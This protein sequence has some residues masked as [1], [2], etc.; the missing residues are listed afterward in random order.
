METTTEYEL[1]TSDWQDASRERPVSQPPVLSLIR[2]GFSTFGPLAP[3]LAARLAYL[4]FTTPRI[5]ARH[6]TSDEW[7][8]KAR[9]FEITYKSFRLKAYEWG[10][11]E[12]VILLVHGW[13]SR[14]TALRSFVPALLERG[15][16][17]VAFDG[18]AHGDSGGKRTNIRHFA[19]A[20]RSIMLELGGVY[21]II[22]HSFGG[23]STIYALGLLNSGLRMAKAVFI[24]TPASVIPIYE[25]IVRTLNL[26][27][28]VAMHFKNLME[29]IAGRPLVDLDAT[30]GLA[31]RHIGKILLIHDRKDSVVP[32]EGSFAMAAA[33]ENAHLLLTDG[34]GH[35]RLMKNPD[36]VN[37]VGEF[38]GEE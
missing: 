36:L 28:S 11:G 27:P 13:E 12:R 21:G 38:F 22:G 30:R 29:R 7:L 8:E 16:R 25:D 26:P 24:A 17:V 5:R 35:Y 23:A 1:L 19:G 31:S 15:F 37:R 18:P 14:G 4:L 9:R 6:S 32:L 33:W 10:E 20:V 2:W 3:R 34:Y